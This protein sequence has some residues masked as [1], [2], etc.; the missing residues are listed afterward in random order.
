MR[1]AKI[2][3]DKKHSAQKENKRGQLKTR[4]QNQQNARKNERTEE[5]TREKNT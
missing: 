2:R 4:E 3:E 5:T 1:K